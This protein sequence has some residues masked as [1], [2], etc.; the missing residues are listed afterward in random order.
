MRTGRLL[1][2][3][4]GTLLCCSEGLAQQRC[5]HVALEKKGTEVHAGRPNCRRDAGS[6]VVIALA[7]SGVPTWHMLLLARIF[8][9]EATRLAEKCVLHI[10]S[11]NVTSSRKPCAV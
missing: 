5:G 8:L 7:F 4:S 3:H 6:G 2:T 11:N 9:L 1:R 10:A